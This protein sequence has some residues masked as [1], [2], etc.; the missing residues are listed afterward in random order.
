MVLVL[1]LLSFGFLWVQGV[2]AG[3]SGS[4]TGDEDLFSGSVK[5]NA[6]I[7]LDNSNS[8]DEDFFGNA[9]GS[10]ATGSKSVEGKRVLNSLVNIYANSIR[11]GLMSYRLNPVTL[12]YLM[13]TPYFVS[14]D[15]RSYCPSPPSECVDYCR[16]G[17]L[18]SKGTCQT[19]CVAQNSVF[20]ATVIDDTISGLPI[21]NALRTKYCGL[22][23]P[24]TTRMLN[25]SD[26]GKYLYYKQALPFYS[27]Y[28]YQDEFDVAYTYTVD[29]NS[30]ND[31]Y[32]QYARKT[33]TSD[34]TPPTGYYLNPNGATPYGYSTWKGATGFYP[35]D[36]DIAL[37]Y[38]E[39]GK[40]IALF[41][42]GRSFYANNSP[43]DGYL[44]VPAE[45]ND[46][47]NNTQLNS[48][49]AKLKTYEGNQAGYLGDCLDTWNPNQCS[50]ILNAGLTPTPGTLKSAASYFQGSYLDSSGRTVSSPIQ[51]NAKDCQKSYIIYVTDGLPSVDENGFPRDADALMAG[52]LSKITALRSLTVPSLSKTFDIKTY[53]VGVGLTDEAK[54]KLDQMAVAGGT[55]VSGR[56]YYADNSAELQEALDQIFTEIS[57]GNYC[58]S[59]PS[60]SSVRTADESYLYM[61]SFEPKSGE[62]FWTG[63]LKKVKIN[64][65]GTLDDSCTECWDAGTVL[66]GTSDG[67]DYTL[68]NRKIK[69]YIDGAL[70]DFTRSISPVNFGLSSSKTEERN[71][72]VDYI[73]GKETLT[74]GGRNYT[75]PDFPRKLGDTFHSNPITVGTP[76]AFF[77][78]PRDRNKAF[79]RFRTNHPR[80]SLN[81]NRVVM[82]GAND[83]QLHAFET[84]QGREAWSFI[85]PN[86]LGKLNDI[87][88]VS[89]PTTK[90]HGYFVDGPV[91]ISDAWLPAHTGDGTAKNEPDWKT[92][93]VFGLGV[94][95]RGSGD[96]PD[97]LWSKSPSCDEDFQHHYSDEYH[98]YCG[99]FALDVTDTKNPKFLW[100][101]KP[102][103]GDGDTDYDDSTVS[104]FAE[105]WS[106]M[107]IGKVKVNG[108]EK[109]VGFIGG[110]YDN[111]NDNKKGKGFFVVNLTDGKIVWSH[112]NKNSSAM[113][114]VPGAAAIVDKDGDGFIDTAYIGDLAGNL[115]K[116]SFCP[117]SWSGSTPCSTSNWAATRLF[118]SQGGNSPIFSTPVVARDSAYYW[119]FWGT[120][121]KAYPNNNGAQNSFFA[122]KDQSPA[123]PYTV[124]DLENITSSQKFS[125]ASKKGWYLNLTGQERVLADAAVYAGMVFFTSY[126]PPTGQNICG[127]VGD[128]A[129]YGI[130]MMPVSVGGAKYDPGKGVF[131]RDG[132]RKV[133]L[134]KGVASAP[135]ISLKPI[136]GANG[137][138][139]ENNT[140]DLFVAVS[141]GGAAAAQIQ[142]GSQIPEVAQALA[143][144]VPSASVLHWKD[145]RVQ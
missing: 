98:H 116:F 94:G 66:E 19:S 16:T 50:Y 100:R 64:A 68:G 23:H 105:P 84:G 77:S 143:G 139:A 75:H 30:A 6:L 130:A 122:V 62:S 3:P 49:L 39:F 47:K 56:A 65:D 137:S 45:D 33:G 80:T 89:H 99:Y 53:V 27:F 114:Y 120:G 95:V 67:N 54:A 48:L 115:W 85:P 73:R 37:G 96:K 101:L 88:H 58:F 55:D 52:V 90:K 145:R 14:Y 38:Q 57:A 31:G 25:P 21:G 8:M 103:Y 42:S 11:L 43:G 41:N 129:L 18:V 106:R 20:D 78:D 36:S 7:I 59:L 125:D 5:P 109:W 26:P 29:D 13:N 60:V 74:S 35:T 117:D 24:K 92:V 110:G 144:H 46:S 61:G 111:S 1:A 71:L 134:G 119:V 28:P 133:G 131:S 132:L 12:S 141:G 70:T 124:A 17:S 126:T 93:L 123:S 135:V 9:V 40:R 86:L 128:A 79:E 76:S 4:T 63:H 108:N 87:V 138:T 32:D 112:T 113:S 104:Y 44:H 69:T 81:G 72:I 51:S 22:V 34:G 15:P 97:Y 82:V 121:D 83:G 142:T 118:N 10:Y 127:A 102:E 136:G 140:A 91:S 107:V 2:H